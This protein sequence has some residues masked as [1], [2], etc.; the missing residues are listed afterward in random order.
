VAH[1]FGSNLAAHQLQVHVAPD[2]LSVHYTADVPNAM[3][4]TSTS[5]ASAD[6][7]QAMALDLHTGLVLVVDG[8]S[9]PLEATV[10]WTVEATD[11]TQRFHGYYDAPLTEGTHQLSLSNGNLP[12]VVSVHSVIATVSDSLVVEDTNLW[13]H[14][15]GKLVR[16][17]NGRWRTTDAART[18]TLTTHKLSFPSRLWTSAE[19]VPLG[20]ARAGSR[21]GLM[22]LALGA[23]A[24][25]GAVLV[26]ASRRSR[27]PA[28]RSG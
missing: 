9:V 14:H 18:L 26:L 4:R 5:D 6:P 10:P 20:E 13:R 23:L 19:A 28:Q 11:D 8:H 24:A 2:H 22:G 25:L 27:R 1:P 16:D 7:L 15:N 3:V 12:G 17:D 21:S